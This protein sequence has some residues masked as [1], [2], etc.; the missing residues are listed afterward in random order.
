MNLKEIKNIYFLGIGGI[1]M[2]ALAR[3]F[4]A[5]GIQVSGY[6]K[7]STPLTKQ[8]EEE[9]IEVHYTENIDIIPTN[10]DVVIYTPAVPKD[11]IEYLYFIKQNIPILKR[12]EVLGLLTKNFK[13]IAIAGTHGKTTITTMVTH[14]LKCANFKITSFMGGISK[15]YDTNIILSKENQF[16]VVEADEY[17]KSFLKLFPHIAV[18]TSM[19]ADHLDIYGD[20]TIC[21]KLLL[22]L[23]LRLRKMDFWC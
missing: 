5:M 4:K 15:N 11:N 8:L 6:D 7:T 23:P 14:I 19:D 10:V 21:N 16:V 18:I 17:D 12:A 13:T 9:G 1:G 20:K 2:S 3:Y 22:N